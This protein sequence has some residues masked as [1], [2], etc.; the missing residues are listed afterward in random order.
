MTTSQ[1]AAATG[2]PSTPAFNLLEA[3][4]AVIR[5]RN[6]AEGIMMACHGLSIP[7]E[8]DGLCALL[9]HLHGELDWLRNRL[10]EVNEGAAP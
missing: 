1:T 3:A 4:D 8:R 10:D 6:T 7:E 9:V 5:A 2:L